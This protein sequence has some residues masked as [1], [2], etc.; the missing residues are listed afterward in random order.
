MLEQ[1]AGQVEGG[2][3]RGK[4]RERVGGLFKHGGFKET[5]HLCLRQPFTESGEGRLQVKWTQEDD[6]MRMYMFKFTYFQAYFSRPSGPEVNIS[7]RPR[8]GWLPLSC[9]WCR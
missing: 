8:Q 9:C 3:E 2:R 7:G 1:I 6:S 5:E 4:E